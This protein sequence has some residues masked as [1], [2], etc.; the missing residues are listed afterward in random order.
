MRLFERQ[1]GTGG[2]RQ[3]PLQLGLVG[4]IGLELAAVAPIR[5][6][7]LEGHGMDLG[8]LDVYARGV[9]LQ[10]T[11]GDPWSLVGLAPLG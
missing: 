11:A 1:W 2:R 5:P 9:G 10:G 8:V 3:Q 7:Q 6:G 4:E